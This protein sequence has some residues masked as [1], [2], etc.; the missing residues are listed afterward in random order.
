[1]LVIGIVCNVLGL[2]Q[3]FFDTSIWPLGHKLM[4]LFGILLITLISNYFYYGD[5]IPKKLESNRKPG[6]RIAII[7]VYLLIVISFLIFSV[8]TKLYNEPEN[9]P[10]ASPSQVVADTPNITTPSQTDTPAP[11]SSPVPTL[12]SETVTAA[13]PITPTPFT[14]IYGEYDEGVGE[15]ESYTKGMAAYYK[16]D[17]RTAFPYLL[18]AAEEGYAPAQY[19]L[20]ACYHHGTGTKVDE[21]KAFIWYKLSADQYYPNGYL[22]T[23]Y[24]YQYGVGVEQDYTAAEAYYLAAQE[25]GH[26]NAD[27][28]LGDLYRIMSK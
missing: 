18:V 13:S 7:V 14:L 10:S 25:A 1:M 2:F 22:W 16:W 4:V 15:P 17:Y 28:R 27:N 9:D 11:V 23:G 19:Q 5:I 24:C 6:T 20:G 26:K 8:S 12:P 3:W 21:E